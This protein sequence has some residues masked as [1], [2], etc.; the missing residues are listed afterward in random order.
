MNAAD[1]RGESHQAQSHH[2][3]QNVDIDTQ[4]HLNEGQCT[5]NYTNSTPSVQELYSIIKNIRSNASPGPDGL[6]AAFFKSAWQWIS[7]DVHELVI[8][9]YSS[10]FMHPDLNQT[11]IALIPKKMH[12][13]TPHDFRPISLCNI[14]YKIISKSLADRLKPHLPN[15][16][17][18]SQTAFIKNMH[19]SAN[20]I[21]T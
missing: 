15:Y 19:I 10:V 17:D 18:P 20:I 4:C 2:Q 7:K 16:I 9:F 13:I 5:M 6:S 1:H 21:I 12:P 8:E 11:F 14:I 3:Q